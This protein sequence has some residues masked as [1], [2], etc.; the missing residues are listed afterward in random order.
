MATSA[1][2]EIEVAPPRQYGGLS[3]HILFA[4]SR[5]ARE[6][7]HLRRNPRTWQLFRVA[8]GLTGAGLVILPLS[9]WESWTAGIVGLVLFTASVLL[10]RADTET[11]G[12]RKARELGAATVLDG[13]KYQPGNAPAAAV[14]IFVSA[15]HIWALD[16]HL[17][18]LLV[19]PAPEISSVRAEESDGRWN[20]R[21]R[22]LDHT[23]DFYYR[24]IFAELLA[25]RAETLLRAALPAARPAPPKRRAA[26]A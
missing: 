24:G 5:F 16:F 14:Q 26:T 7:L 4:L 22:W 19:I 10:P 15:E 1:Q 17:Q 9:L 20:L 12:N 8:L 25:R 18:P 13:G 2:Q 11:P 21:I 23:A 6:M 3:L